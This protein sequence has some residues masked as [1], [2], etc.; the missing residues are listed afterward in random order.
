ME[1]EQ[2]HWN[3]SKRELDV[4][5]PTRPQDTDYWEGQQSI[6]PYPWKEWL[7]G[8]FRLLIQGRDFH[9]EM[10]SFRTGLLAQLR[11][12]NV[13]GIARETC[14]IIP[15][16]GEVYNCFEF[17]AK[18]GE[19]YERSAKFTPRG[20]RKHTFDSNLALSISTDLRDLLNAVAASRGINRTA[21]IRSILYQHLR[22]L[23]YLDETMDV[24]PEY[25]QQPDDAKELVGKA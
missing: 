23:N 16:T 3:M 6:A 14:V 18:P 8:N 4:D 9:S 7:D 22:H 21:L 5:H 12:R 20:R 15:E 1:R 11:R 24:L 10:G 13:K 17:Q 19:P 2:S 25:I